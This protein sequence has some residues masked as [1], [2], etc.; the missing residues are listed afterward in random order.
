[1]L[2]TGGGAAGNGIGIAE[3]EPAKAADRDE[4][5]RAEVGD[6]G[7][8]GRGGEAR[9]IDA[10]REI[11]DGEAGA[12]EDEGGDE[13]DVLRPDGVIRVGVEAEKSDGAHPELTGDDGD[14]ESDSALAPIRLFLR[15]S[16]LSSI[17]PLAKLVLTLAD[18]T[19]LDGSSSG[20]LSLALS[21]RRW[22]RA[23]RGVSAGSSPSEF[24]SAPLALNVGESSI[25]SAAE[26][27]NQCPAQS[28]TAA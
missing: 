25:S 6:A 18:L 28:V 13:K 19:V 22:L 15:A 21:V 9:L 20:E 3:G 7:T 23:G 2:S 11:D 1:M 27:V 5:G 10:R 26:W 24:E 8:N 16:A 14:D 12:L 17:P 4:R